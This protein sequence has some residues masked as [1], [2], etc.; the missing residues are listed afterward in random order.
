MIQYKTLESSKGKQSKIWTALSH[1]I[2]YNSCT[3]IDEDFF[4]SACSVNEN[5]KEHS[6]KMQSEILTYFCFP[7]LN[8]AISLRDGDILLFNPLTYHCCSRKRYAVS[9]DVHIYSLYLKSK[10]VSLNK[11]ATELTNLQKEYLLALNDTYQ[12]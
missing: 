5:N 9:N 1:A 2:N 8:T 6:Y 7:T 12:K 10:H 11:N 3:H 4:L